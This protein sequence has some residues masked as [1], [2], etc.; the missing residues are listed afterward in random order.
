[1]SQVTTD[2]TI[3]SISK[4]EAHCYAVDNGLIDL[5]NVSYVAESI[6]TAGRYGLVGLRQLHTEQLYMQLTNYISEAPDTFQQHSQFTTWYCL[7][8]CHTSAE[9]KY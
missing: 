2:S 4:V 1:M 5:E 7:S 6:T 3:V 9:F 8:S